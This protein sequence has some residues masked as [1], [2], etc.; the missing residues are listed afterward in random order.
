[1][2]PI[3]A[4]IYCTEKSKNREMPL[5]QNF[6]KQFLDD[7]DELK[8]EGITCSSVVYNLVDNGVFVCDAPARSSLRK[9]KQHCGYS[10]CE[11]CTV[12]G[13][14]DGTARHV[15]FIQTN[16]KRRTNHDFLLQ[17]DREHHIGRSILATY[18]VNMI[19]DF[20]LDYM[21]LWCLGVMKRML[22]WWKRVKR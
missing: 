15:C 16:C 13:D 3:C 2:R 21:H 18:G 19:H 6:L 8:S 5:P 9:I 17:S 11:R 10:S 22:M 12:I 1:M 7:L 20:P 4:G 14:Y